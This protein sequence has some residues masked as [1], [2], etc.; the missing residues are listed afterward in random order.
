MGQFCNK[1]VSEQ[2]RSIFLHCLISWAVLN[3]YSDN[4][5]NKNLMITS[6]FLCKD[7]FAPPE[8]NANDGYEEQEDYGD[9]QEEY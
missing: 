8:E 7:G 4:L 9:E 3:K 6:L 1:Q 2:M 5:K